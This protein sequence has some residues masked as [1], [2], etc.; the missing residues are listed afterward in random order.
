MSHA[1]AR[2]AAQRS[3]PRLMRACREVEGLFLRR[4]L[5]AMDRPSFGEGIL[6]SS[7]GSRIF[8][9]RRNQ[10][11][12]DEMGRRGDL[13][14]AQMLY[15]DLTDQTGAAERDSGASLSQTAPANGGTRR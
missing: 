1:A 8:R 10:A 13:E 4:L 2:S 7:N 11:L 6:G 15:E 12:A 9:A 14:L 5:D 3:H